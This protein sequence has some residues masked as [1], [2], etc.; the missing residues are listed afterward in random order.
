MLWLQCNQ[1]QWLKL[2]KSYPLQNRLCIWWWRWEIDATIWCWPQSQPC[3]QRI[4]GRLAKNRKIQQLSP[5]G[6]ASV[7]NLM[8][9]NNDSIFTYILDYR[10]GYSVISDQSN[11]KRGDISSISN[12]I[13]Q[14]KIV[15][16]V[17]VSKIQ[18]TYYTASMMNTDTT[19]KRNFDCLPCWILVRIHCNAAL[20]FET[21]L[22]GSSSFL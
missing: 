17:I 14:P 22:G 7:I 2:V 15:R 10:S 19:R 18:H 4:V 20:R 13:K 5:V 9:V 3:P 1:H 8:V 16:V 11:R 12:F 6:C 21:P